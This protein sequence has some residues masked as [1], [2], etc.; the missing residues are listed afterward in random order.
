MQPRKGDYEGAWG[1]L[2]FVV[3]AVEN[4]VALTW[5][6]LE[7]LRVENLWRRQG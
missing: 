4:E 7:H 5:G 3:D 1:R 6:T 2:Q